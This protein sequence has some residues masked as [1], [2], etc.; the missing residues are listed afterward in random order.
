MNSSLQ[1]AALRYAARGWHV[2]PVAVNGKIA[3]I[4]EWEQRA[5]TDPDRITRCWAQAPYNIGIACGPS[6]LVVIDLDRPKLGQ[7]PPAEWQIS[8][9]NDGFDAFAFLCEREDQ[10]LPVLTH[11]VITGRKGTHLYFTHPAGEQLRNTSGT[12]GRGLGWLIDTRAHGGY[13]LGAGS[14]VNGRTYQTLHEEEQLL[15]LPGWLAERLTPAPLPEPKQVTVAPVADRRGRY[16]NAAVASQVESVEQAGSGEKNIK[17]F[18]SAVALGQLVAGGS[19]QEHEVI[20][21]L[22]QAAFRAYGANRFPAR[23]VS[24]TIA[25]G[26]KTG[27]K[28]PRMVS[29]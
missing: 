8:G 12:S 13:V 4:K 29:A 15:T 6:D 21:L 24:R 16:L 14:V 10:P 2:F 1:A 3:A 28:R 25:S 20:S 27:A 18:A 9:V 7:Q 5:T 22:T 19:L 17:L 23:E 11:T 26:L